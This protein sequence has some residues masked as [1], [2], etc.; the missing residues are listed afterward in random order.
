M[1]KGTIF[2]VTEISVTDHYP[3]AALISRD[4]STNR[5]KSVL[6]RSFATFN[7]DKFNNDLNAKLDSFMSVVDTLTEN[8]VNDILN[9]FY[10]LL[11]STINIHAP[12]KKLS[13]KQKRLI[14]KPWITKGLL[15]S[16]KKKQKMHKTH[17]IKVSPIDKLCYKTYSNVLTKVKNLAKKLYYHHKLN[18]NSHNP[19]KNLG[20]FAYS[21]T[22]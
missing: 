11:T 2:L 6:S 14:N 9:D 3:V 1:R 10:S 13:R 21:V 22:H 12:L 7:R 4:L 8:N 16:I 19:K 20:R 5:S 15:I 18:D 17:Y